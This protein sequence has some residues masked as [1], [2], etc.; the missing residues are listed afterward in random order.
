MYKKPLQVVRKATN[1][2]RC[3]GESTYQGSFL[4]KE[5]EKS[6]IKSGGAEKNLCR[7]PALQAS[8]TTNTG[9]RIRHDPEAER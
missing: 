8:G 7:G 5:Q 4:Q 2:A 6:S 3:K 1:C 9:A